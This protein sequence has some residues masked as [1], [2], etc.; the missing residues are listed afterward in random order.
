MAAHSTA[1]GC[2]GVQECRVHA[3][4]FSCVCSAQSSDACVWPTTSSASVWPR[5]SAV[6]P[7]ETCRSASVAMASAS[8]SLGQLSAVC[9]VRGVRVG[10]RS[11]VVARR[12]VV[13]K[14]RLRVCGVYGQS[15]A[16][17]AS[18]R[19]QRLKALTL[20]RTA[21]LYGRRAA[22]NLHAGL[23]PSVCV[24]WC[25]HLSILAA[26]ETNINSPRLLA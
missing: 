4:L 12:F 10:W 11:S 2:R 14:N 26:R 3:A 6:A 20:S 5:A 24:R 9:S 15:F 1:P 23:N 8:C 21:D 22:Q 25:A 13:S 17:T 19:P 7:A 18:Q 16:H